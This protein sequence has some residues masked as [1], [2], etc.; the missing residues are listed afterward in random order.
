MTV[1]LKLVDCINVYLKHWG[2]LGTVRHTLTRFVNVCV[3]AEDSD[4][5]RVPAAVGDRLSDQR[6]VQHH[7]ERHRQA[8]ETQHTQSCFNEPLLY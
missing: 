6:V 4:R 1:L 8:G 3:V 7:P 5:Q 2:A